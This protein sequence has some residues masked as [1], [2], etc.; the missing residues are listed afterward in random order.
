MNSRSA[1]SAPAA[2]A[3]DMPA[4]ITPRG[5]VVRS[6]RAAIPPVARMMRRRECPPSRPRARLPRRSASKR[7]PSRSRSRTRSGESS[8]STRTALSRAAARPAA[9]VS[10]A[11]R[12]GE[13]SSA[14]AAAIPPW[15]QYDAVWASGERLTSATRAPSPAAV[16]AAYRPAAPAPTTATSARR[17]SGSGESMAARRYGTGARASAPQP[18]LLAAARDR[19]G[20]PRAR[21]PDARDPGGARAPRLARIRAPRGPAGDREAA[22]RRAHTPARGRGAG[23]ERARRRVRPRHADLGGLLGRRAPRRRRRLRARGGAD[24]RRRGADR[25]LPAAPARASCGARPG[26]GL[27]PVREPLRGGPPRARFDGGR[28]RLRARLGRPPRQRD[29]LDL[30]LI[31]GGP[32]REHPPVPVLS[33]HRPALR[34]GLGRRRGLLDQFAGAGRGGRGR[35]LRPRRARGAP[36][37]AGVRPRSGA[38]GGR[39]RRA[40]PRPG[41]RLR[42]RHLLVR[43]A[44]A[45]GA[46]AR[47]AGRLRARGRL[48]PRRLGRLGGGDDGGAGGRRRAALASAGVPRGGGGLGGRPLLALVT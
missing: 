30:P 42:A 17:E 25:L 20:P 19:H 47:Q 22:A 11:W 1:S 29:E 40:P 21:R 33:R 13:S 38:G 43:R 8:Q 27:L 16:S 44:H 24:E 36:R 32:L 18:S 12:P 31:A 7:T 35:L 39:V 23:D 41:G 5:F 45:P 28:A 4:P 37:C 14:S 46:V 3:S 34:R 10:A 15:A 2:T 26:N 6:H 48:R 9:T